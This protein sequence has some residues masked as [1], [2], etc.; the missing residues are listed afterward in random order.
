[1]D[2]IEL[3]DKGISDAFDVALQAGEYAL[4]LKYPVLGFPFIKQIW[5][6]FLGDLVGKVKVQFEKGA[7]VVII[8]I[9]TDAQN[10]AA[11]AAAQALKDI[12]S[13]LGVP[14]AEHQKAIDDFKA[15]YEDLIRQRTATPMP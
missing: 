7:N 13:K 15:R 2:G 1:M 14:D 11:E 10:A 6:F 4:I 3:A 5:E 9:T 12:Q 8:K